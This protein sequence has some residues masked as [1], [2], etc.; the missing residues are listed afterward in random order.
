MVT[1]S[2]LAYGLR[3]AGASKEISA[4][5]RLELA[6]ETRKLAGPVTAAGNSPR[7]IHLLVQ[8]GEFVERGQ[9]LAQFDTGPAL[10]AERRLLQ[11]RY[12]SL[13]RQAGNL[14][15]EVDRYRQLVQAG[16]LARADLQDREQQLVE[17]Q[18]GVSETRQAITRTDADLVNSELRAP[19]AGRVMRLY[20]RVGERPGVMG[21]L[22]LST[23]DRLEAV[24]EVADSDLARIHLGQAA[25]INSLSGAFPGTLSAR[26]SRVSPADEARGDGVVEVRLDLA[27]ADARRVRKLAGL[28]TITHF[29]S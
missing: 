15:A 14:Q 21:I 20:A 9:L 22:E 28:R 16:A 29:A 3:S 17:L 27:P 24:A 1:A 11:S 13:S 19:V 2:G 25:R 7:L 4:P 5:G 6:G 26:V 12:A 18:S 23:S 8:E 10:Q